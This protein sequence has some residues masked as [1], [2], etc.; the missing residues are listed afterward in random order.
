M[1]LAA[2]SK[3]SWAEKLNEQKREE[4]GSTYYNGVVGLPRL[5]L[6]K[7]NAPL[8]EGTCILYPFVWDVRK[9]RQYLTSILSGRS[10]VA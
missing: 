1:I 5:H 6:I 10:G 4:E 3:R 2:H 9:P 8:S 7:N